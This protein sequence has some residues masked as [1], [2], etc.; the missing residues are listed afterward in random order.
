MFYHYAMSD[1]CQVM[2]QWGIEGESYTEAADGTRSFTEQANDNDWLQQL[3]INPSFVFPA[4]QSVESTDVLVAGWHAECNAWQK[5]FVKDPWPFVYST[6]QESEVINTYMVDIQ[7][8]VDENAN[9]FITGTKSLD[10]FDSYISGLEALN[11]SEVLAV[12]Q[13][14]YQR[15]LSALE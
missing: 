15:Y 2:Y 8:Y 1:S 14:Q 9:A 3:G 6:E 10:E 7:T 11:L 4:Q 12:K 5:Q 13:A